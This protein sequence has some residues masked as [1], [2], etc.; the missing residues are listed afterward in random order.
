MLGMDADEKKLIEQENL[1]RD[2]PLSKLPSLKN[3]VDNVG[4]E[5]CD[6][7]ESLIK[8]T[9]KA[10]KEALSF[11][12]DTESRYVWPLILRVLKLASKIREEAFAAIGVVE[13][14]SEEDNDLINWDGG[15]L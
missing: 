3:L 13:D 8:H 5:G 4:V 9:E 14:D 11:D 1:F 12:M 7:T 2:M 6:K 10:L 15:E